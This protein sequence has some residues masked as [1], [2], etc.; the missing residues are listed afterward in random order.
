MYRLMMECD[1][2]QKCKTPRI[3]DITPPPLQKKKKNEI[4]WWMQLSEVNSSYYNYTD[5]EK[6]VV[7]P[8]HGI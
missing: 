3:L 7:V 4:W 5:A 6:S 2:V 8:Y 1:G